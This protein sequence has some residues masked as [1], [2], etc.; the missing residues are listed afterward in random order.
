MFEME[1]VDWTSVKDMFGDGKVMKY[2]L[3]E[4][5]GWERPLDRSEVFVNVAAKTVDNQILWEA[6]DFSFVVGE[7][8]VPEFLDKVLK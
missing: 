2:I 7:N 6:K 1:L 4:G 5:T 3:E 8:K